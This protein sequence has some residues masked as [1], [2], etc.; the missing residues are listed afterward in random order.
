[1]RQRANFKV[2]SGLGLGNLGV[3]RGPLGAALATLETKAQLHAAAP[4]V[5]R[6]AVDGHVA[7]VHVFVAQLGGT[8]VHDLEVVVARQPGNAVGAGHAHLVFSLGVVGLQVRQGD[9]PVQQIGTFDVAINRLGAELMR[10][11]AQ[12]GAGPVGGGAAHG[13]ANPGWQ[14]GKVFGHPPGA[15]GGAL[16]QPGQLAER[17]PFVV[18]EGL[19]GLQGARLQHHHLD[20]LLAQFV[21]QRAAARA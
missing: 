13:L 4:A 18:D 10:L 19:F 16:V 14:T 20:A 21:G 12:R 1:M 15:R 8:R 3:Q 7:G 2:A 6:L 9:G 5:A 17:L 11:K